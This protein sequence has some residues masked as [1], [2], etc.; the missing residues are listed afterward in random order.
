MAVMF[1]HE[2]C[3]ATQAATF[4]AW[5]RCFTVVLDK[6]CSLGLGLYYDSPLHGSLPLCIAQRAYE[7]VRAYSI[8]QSAYLR[9]SLCWQLR[10]P[11]FIRLVNT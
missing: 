5:L 3:Q 11:T 10:R 4:E 6:V 2:I 7:Q 8:L 1:Y 9:R